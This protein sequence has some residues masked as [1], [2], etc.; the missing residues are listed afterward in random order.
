MSLQV[1][2]CLSDPVSGA[3]GRIFNILLNNP[4]AG[5][6]LQAFIQGSEGRRVLASVIEAVAKGLIDELKEN[7]HAKVSGYANVMTGEIEIEA[8]IL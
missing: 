3:A 6:Y 7:G 1:G 8:P 5:L 4:D 2:Q